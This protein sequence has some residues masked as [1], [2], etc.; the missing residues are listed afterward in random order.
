MNRQIAML[1]GV[2]VLSASTAGLAWDAESRD[3]V[4]GKAEWRGNPHLFIVEQAIELLK[5]SD[6]PRSGTR[7]RARGSWR[8]TA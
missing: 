8:A 3:S 1:V 5:R 4:G 6:V 7:R 2:V